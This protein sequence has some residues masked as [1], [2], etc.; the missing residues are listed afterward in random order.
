MELHKGHIMTA[1]VILDSY[2]NFKKDFETD[3]R[4]NNMDEIVIKKILIN[5]DLM[6][7]PFKKWTTKDH[8]ILIQ[9]ISYVFFKL[10]HM[11]NDLDECI[12]QLEI[13][14]KREKRDGIMP[15]E[16]YMNY[17]RTNFELQK[18]TEYLIKKDAEYQ[19]FF[20]D[21]VFTII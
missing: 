16:D 14:S 4:A 20:N 17:R 15:L 11:K 6:K 3:M 1:W 21:E 5:I 18:A 12:R 13:R 7:I 2:M 8:Y 9:V 10:A 19:I